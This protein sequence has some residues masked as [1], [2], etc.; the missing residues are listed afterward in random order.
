M[1]FLKSYGLAFLIVAGVAIWMLTGT[2][3]EGGKGPG[4][5]ERPLVDA[6]DGDD[7]P[8]RGFFE[9][10]GLVQPEEEQTQTIA[11]AQID[12]SEEQVIQS[13]RVRTVEAEDLPQVIRMRGRTEANAIVTARAETNGTVRQVHVRKGQAVEAGDLLC[14]LDQGTR[15]AALATAEAQLAQAQ[16]DLENNQQLRERGVAPA[17]TARQVEV[18]LLSAQANYDQALA[19]LERTEIHADVPGIVQDPLATVGDSLSA[20]AECATLIQLDPMVFIGEVPEAQV[21]LLAAGENALVSTVTGQQVTGEVRFV[22]A[23]ANEAT[24]TFTV[25]IEVPNNDGLIRHGVTAEAFVDVGNIRAHLVPQSVL[26]L[27]TDGQLGIRT[28]ED[29]I[30]AFYPIEIV[31]DTREGSWVTGLPEVADVITLGQ[32]YVQAGQQVAASHGD[33]A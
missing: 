20:G 16:A 13:V 5:G 31:R 6:V 15:Q 10:I 3:I 33:G 25:E 21:G 27:D 19:E 1:R 18:A 2:L 9:A 7:G 24:R 32:E 22:S 14:S 12:E 28:V 29:G 26:T 8:L 23:S 4:Q 11:A 30:V 17:N